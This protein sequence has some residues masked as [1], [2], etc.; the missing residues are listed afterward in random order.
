MRK[1][2]TSEPFSKANYLAHSDLKFKSFFF[3]DVVA[4]HAANLSIIGLIHLASIYSCI[5][6]QRQQRCFVFC[7]PQAFLPQA[8]FWKRV[9]G[10]NKNPFWGKSQHVFYLSL[11]FLCAGY[12]KLKAVD[13]SFPSLV[14][15][16]GR[17]NSICVRR[18]NRTGKQ[19][20]Y[21]FKGFD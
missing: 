8:R 7:L 21:L 16:Q 12:R 13:L 6:T 9:E 18:E 11:F 20:E 3:F 10:I 4:N 1:Q 5:K 2:A 14:L 15:F 17:V 19:M